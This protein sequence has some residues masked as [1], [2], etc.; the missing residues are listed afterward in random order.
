MAKVASKKGSA[1]KKKSVPCGCGVDYH[2]D[3]GWTKSSE[4]EEVVESEKTSSGTSNRAQAHEILSKV[5]KRRGQLDRAR[6]HLMEILRHYPNDVSAIVSLGDV[7]YS[8]SKYSEAME[9]YSAA[10][11]AG[12]DTAE[13]RYRLGLCAKNLG[14]L[15]TAE[16]HLLKAIEL[17]PTYLDAHI[18]LGRLYGERNQLTEALQY[19]AKAVEIDPTFADAYF[20]AA[21]MLATAGR[22]KD[23]IDVYR[24][25]LAYSPRNAPI[26]VDLGNCYIEIGA[27]E[28]AKMA[29]RQALAIRPDRKSVV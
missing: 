19:F 15:E 17:R 4:Q 22:F 28:L 12:K 14:E 8:Q 10:L 7:E 29:F 11:T 24:A 18:E 9:R 13:I 21:Q 2:Y 26:F 1:K 25:G 27:Y 6:Q 20:A 3:P 23:A 5:Y 16:K